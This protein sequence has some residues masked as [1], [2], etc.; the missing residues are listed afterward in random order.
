MPRVLMKLM[1]AELDM[2]GWA[3]VL[4]A[5]LSEGGGL[6]P[7]A[8][9]GLK[10]RALRVPDRYR[11]AQVGAGERA[12]VEE[13]HVGVPAATLF[14]DAL[15][16]GAEDIAPVGGAADAEALAA[17]LGGVLFEGVCQAK[18]RLDL[19]CVHTVQKDLADSD[20]PC[21]KPRGQCGEVGRVGGAGEAP[22]LYN[23]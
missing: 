16:V 23:E 4:M 5:K 20:G 9:H 11:A 3:E 1:L 17:E 10:V 13:C 12:L 14:D 15:R 6:H 8:A 2:R 21:R 7:A 18:P 19:G 22:S